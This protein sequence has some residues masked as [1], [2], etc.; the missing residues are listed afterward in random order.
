MTKEQRTILI[1][2]L[3]FV[4]TFFTTTIAGA[5]WSFG[6]SIFA[7]DENGIFINQE[8][9]WSDFSKGLPF[10]LSLLFIL[11]VHEFGHYFVAIWHKVKTSLPYYIPLPPIPWL[12]FSLGTFGAVI[13]M[14]SRPQTNLQIFDVGLAGP[15]AGYVVAVVLLIYG[16]S[17][18]PSHE[19]VFQF[20][21]EYQ[22]Y[23]AKYADIVYTEEFMKKHVQPGA[24]VGD[25]VIGKNLM[26]MIAELFVSDPSRI[27]NSHELMHYPLLL[28]V[29]FALFVTSLNLIPI[30]QFD[31]GHVT[32]GLFGY[33][34]HK[35]IA[36]ALFVAL[37]FYAGLGNPYI[38]LTKPKEELLL[39]TTGYAIF[40]YFVFTSLR[41]SRQKTLMYALLMVAAHL[42][43]AM[44]V[45]SLKG[46]DSWLFLA[47]IFGKLI[48]IEH[49]PSEIEHPLDNR[50]VILGWCALA[51]FI[52]CFSPAP[53]QVIFVTGE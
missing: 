10:S 4:A 35:H 34:K 37:I 47:A 11:T 32:Y 3:L 36:T 53:L 25:I 16:F 38:D 49:P 33:R 15:I 41:L 27:P 24:M 14:R 46:Y 21:P 12:L 20:H 39:Y 30:G 7:A 18:L 5:Q 19:Y 43:L 23:G 13:R 2:I 28:G 8:Y 51:I 26:F 50:R 31:G 1:Q 45:P 29:Y 40:I 9:S 42:L 22:E 44:T 6:A 48:G 52:L 17:T